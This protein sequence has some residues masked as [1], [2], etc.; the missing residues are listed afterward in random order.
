MRGQTVE[1]IGGKTARLAH[2]LEPFWPVELDRAGPF[3]RRGSSIDVS[4]R[5]AARATFTLSASGV[6]GRPIR[7]LRVR[8]SSNSAPVAD[9][10]LPSVR[11][12]GQGAVTPMTY[13]AA[14]NSASARTSDV[15]GKSVYVL[16]D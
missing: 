2:T 8:L 10:A 9:L 6:V 12:A 7:A 14:L 13:R 4:R 15:A 16:V 5:H 1:H 11:I 3:D